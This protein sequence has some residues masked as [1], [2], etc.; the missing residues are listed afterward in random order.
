VPTNAQLTLTLLRQGEAN[1][2]PLPPPPGSIAAPPPPPDQ[3][4]ALTQADLRSAG[5]EPPLNASE[6]ELRA[7]IRPETPPE[8]AATGGDI[9]AAKEAKHGKK[10]GRI[11]GLLKG[12]T[13]AVVKTA[14]GT[15]SVRAK[16]GDLPAKE[17][18]G[19]LPN[20]HDNTSVGG[21][22]EFEGRFEGDKGRVYISEAGTVPVLAFG[23]GRGGTTARIAGVDRDD[24]HPVWSVPVGDIVEIKKVGGYGW[25]TKLVVGWSM[26]REVKDGL[27]IR[28]VDGREYKIMALQ[29][30]DE[31]F[32]RLVAL[33]DQKWE[34]W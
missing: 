3:P 17:R 5:A 11:L 15:D 29:L 33:G 21:P 20:A 14:V 19:V 10:G 4:A 28:T 8:P 6:S 24:V 26:D 34:A 7:A 32:N 12:A 30:R 18:L 31:L 23:R 1:R 16:A 9:A 25:K 2:A 27:E 13:R 22:V